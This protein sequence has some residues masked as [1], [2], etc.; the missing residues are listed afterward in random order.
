MS[1]RMKRNPRNLDIMDNRFRKGFLH[2]AHGLAPQ[3]PSNVV[4]IEGYSKGARRL[5]ASN[6]EER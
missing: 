5:R 1:T 3:M 4:Y 2:G 6:R